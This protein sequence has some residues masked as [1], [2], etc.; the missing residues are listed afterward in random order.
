VDSYELRFICLIMCLDV[1]PPAVYE[2][3]TL[4]HFVDACGNPGFGCLGNG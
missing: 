4:P 2:W 3:V 1:F